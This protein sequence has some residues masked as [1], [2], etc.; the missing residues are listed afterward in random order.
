M[1]RYCS[2]LDSSE[3]E[4]RSLQILGSILRIAYMFLYLLILYKYFRFLE[5]AA[6]LG[7]DLNIA[8]DCRIIYIL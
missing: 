3:S 7:L 2:F 6:V 1:A 4:I 5:S 8:L